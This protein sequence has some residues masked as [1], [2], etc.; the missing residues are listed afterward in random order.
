MRRWIGIEIVAHE[1][2]VEL[3][4]LRGPRDLLDRAQI[5]EA[6]DRARIAPAGDVASGS[7][8]EEPEMHPPRRRHHDLRKMNTAGRPG[9]DRLADPSKLDADGP[10]K[11]RHL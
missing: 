6:L 2:D 5:L 8:D 11:V 4:A 1:E 7:E 3:A 9:A 10:G